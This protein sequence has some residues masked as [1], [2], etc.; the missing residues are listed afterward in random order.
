[1]Q[2][3]KHT[4]GYLTYRNG[5]QDAMSTMIVRDTS[6]SYVAFSIHFG[7]LHSFVSLNY[8]YKMQEKELRL[9][10]SVKFVLPRNSLFAIFLS[11]SRDTRLLITDF[12]II[13]TG[14][15]LSAGFSN[16]A[17]K[18]KSPNT[19]RSRQLYASVYRL[20]SR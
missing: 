4:V 2:L 20:A 15:A 1:M 6:R 17:W 14:L 11:V 9:R 3:D 7:L 18:K 5:I 13:C 10:S 8:T 12:V 16:T 19:A